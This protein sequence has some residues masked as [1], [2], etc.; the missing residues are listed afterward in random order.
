M[1][2]DI[3]LYLDYLDDKMD[4]LVSALGIVDFE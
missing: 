3:G 1:Q 4:R 2:E